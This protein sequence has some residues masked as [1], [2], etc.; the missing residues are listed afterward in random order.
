MTTDLYTSIC[1]EHVILPLFI[2]AIDVRDF[3]VWKTSM[4]C[5]HTHTHLSM[6]LGHGRGVSTEWHYRKQWRGK[7]EG[8]M[9]CKAGG[10]VLSSSP[11][12]GLCGLFFN[13]HTAAQD[14]SSEQP[15][16]WAVS[17]LALAQWCKRKHGA[18]LRFGSAG[19]DMVRGKYDL[20]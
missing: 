3:C 9:G 4:R 16:G 17:W 8:G 11:G 6:S 10:G 19:G 15:S 5:R 7:G 13:Q 20:D 14:C 18:T 12:T 1:N 2:T